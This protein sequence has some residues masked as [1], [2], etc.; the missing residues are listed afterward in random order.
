[1]RLGSGSGRSRSD[2]WAWRPS[3]RPG[4]GVVVP[5]TPGVR[6]LAE[7]RRSFAAVSIR[8]HCRP[9]GFASTCMQRVR[10]RR[11]ALRATPR[12]HTST[13][14]PEGAGGSRS[15]A[16]GELTLGLMSGEERWVYAAVLSVGASLLAMNVRAT[17]VLR[18][19]ASS[20]TTIA[21]GL[22]PTGALV[23]GVDLAG[24]VVADVDP[25]P[26]HFDIVRRRPACRPISLGCSCS[27]RI[28]VSA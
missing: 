16:A 10:L 2:P 28:C 18:Q 8:G 14:P 26:P 20:L 1:M 27:H 6:P 12:M 4:F 22:A 24:I 17:R 23:N 19:P 15:K 13:Q 21:S 3:G 9:V 7:A 25:G 11:T 5:F